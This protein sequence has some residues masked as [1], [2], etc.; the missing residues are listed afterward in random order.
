MDNGD[1]ETQS[2][3]AQKGDFATDLHLELEEDGEGKD[4]SGQH[5]LG[6]MYVEGVK[7]EARN[8]RDY[9]EDNRQ[10][11]KCEV[12]GNSISTMAGHERLP[13]LL[14]LIIQDYQHIFVAVFTPNRDSI[15][16]KGVAFRDVGR[17]GIHRNKKTSIKAICAIV[18]IT[19][20]EMGNSRYVPGTKRT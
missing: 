12:K 19:A 17:T 8:L 13:L 15:S 2:E 3:E 6:D 20:I 4:E 16:K 10:R 11:R 14:D 5:R 7:R 9:V 1:E 18:T